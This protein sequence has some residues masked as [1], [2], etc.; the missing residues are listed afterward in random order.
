M[1]GTSIGFLSAADDPSLSPIGRDRAVYNILRAQRDIGGQSRIGI[2]YTDRVLGGDYNR[3]ADVDGRL[4]FG[5]VY[6]DRSSTRKASTRRTSVVRNA[7]LW[8]GISRATASDS[9]SAIR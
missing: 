7:P 4:V 1:T 8:K 5:D 6:S 9:A 3:V 2:A